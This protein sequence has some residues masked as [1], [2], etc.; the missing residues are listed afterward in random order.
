VCGISLFK[1]RFVSLIGRKDK[2]LYSFLF[3][4]CSKKLRMSPEFIQTLL[5]TAKLALSTTLILFIIGLPIAALLAF[6]RFR[7]KVIF[8]ALINMPMVLPPTVIGYYLLV[9]FS[10]QHAF[11]GFLERWFDLRLAFTFQGVLIASVIF[12]LPFMVQPLQNGFVALPKS[13]R[14]AAYT[15]GKSK[16][17]TFF[18]VLV[19]NIKPSIVTAVAMTFAHSI[20][21]FGIVLMVGGN[22]P[23]E[24]RVASIAIYDEV[25]SLNYTTANQYSLILFAVSFVLL[26]IIYSVNRRF[27]I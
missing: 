3:I 23:G 22:M 1:N 16:M 15:L 20:G 9:A 27:R 18:R 26:V 10:P 2:R 19:P 21:E 24:T 8:E 12:S 25:Q 11:G 5:L 6:T 13:Y 17:E 4:L 14:E 7:L